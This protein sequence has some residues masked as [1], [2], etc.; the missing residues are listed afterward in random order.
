MI[1][2][3]PFD[4]RWSDLVPGS[5]GMDKVYLMSRMLHRRSRTSSSQCTAADRN[6]RA[7]MLRLVLRRDLICLS[8]RGGPSPKYLFALFKLLPLHL[9]IHRSSR[10]DFSLNLISARGLALVMMTFVP[11]CSLRSTVILPVGPPSLAQGSKN[12]AM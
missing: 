12:P 6:P 2:Y 9:V 11:S 7:K 4:L 8:G 5:L 3:S 1:R 10:H